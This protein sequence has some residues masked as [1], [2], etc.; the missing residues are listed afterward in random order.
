MGS[1][2][3]RAVDGVGLAGMAAFNAASYAVGVRLLALARRTRGLPETAIGASFL[4]AG[5]VAATGGLAARF[6]A[7]G[8]A[9][10]ALV[11]GMASLALH[12]GVAFLIFF[13]WRVFRPRARWA[14]ALAG[15]LLT[16][17][18]TGFLGPALT[19]GFLAPAEPVFTAISLV[20]RIGLYAWAGLES[21]RCWAQGRRRL[22][23][24]LADPVVVNR[25]LLWGLGVLAVLGIWLDSARQ[26]LAQGDA[27]ASDGVVAVLG[28]L[29]AGCLWLAFFP[30]AAWR[31]RLR[32]AAEAAPQG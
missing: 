30:S 13:V 12:G 31:R 10:H 7:P 25:F 27:Q 2:G 9:G 14:A 8:F 15:F 18:A 28:F 23:L 26:L 3:G 4:L 16:G 21:L 11:S 22:T 29:C 5:G 19:T 24:G 17:L 20:A 6:L 32:G 1:A